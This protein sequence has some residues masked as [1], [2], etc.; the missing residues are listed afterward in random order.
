MNH[1]ITFRIILILLI[2]VVLPIASYFRFQSQSTG[3][4]LDRWQEGLFIMFA[5]RFVGGIGWLGLIAYLVSPSWMAWSSVPLPEWARWTGVAGCFFAGGL[6][7]WTMRSLGKNLTDTVVTRKEHTL[8]TTGPY[9]WVRHP[10]YD[11]AALGIVATS[12]VSANLFLL[13]TGTLV[14]ILLIART[15]TE[16]E[17]LLDRFGDSYRA[18]MARTGKF[19]P[20]IGKV[21]NSVFSAGC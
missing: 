20:K 12:L 14:L 5:L 21:R 13:V 16:E 2:L 15:R 9:Q 4:K 10:F 19:F 18:Y 17:K 11:T 6:L 3:E 7:I 1:D 8:V